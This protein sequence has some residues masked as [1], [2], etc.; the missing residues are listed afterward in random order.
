LA[1]YRESLLISDQ[2]WWWYLDSRKSSHPLNRWD[3][4][5]KTLKL[6][7]LGI[8]FT[9]IGA[10]AARFLGGGSGLIEIGVVIFSCCK[11]FVDYI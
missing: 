6:I 5:A 7:L 4:L 1:E 9:L 10:I 2:V 8:N 3:W 11:I